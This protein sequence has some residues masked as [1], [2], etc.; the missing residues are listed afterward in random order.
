MAV[1]RRFGPWEMG[2][3]AEGL[4]VAEESVS[5][6]F[7]LSD[8][9]WRAYP[10]EV[11]TLAELMPVEVTNK[12]LAQ[13]LRL[14]KPPTANQLRGKDFFRICMQDHNLLR[15]V[16]REGVQDIMLPLLTYVLSHELV[17]IVRFYKFQHLFDAGPQKKEA[18]E[19]KVHDVTANILRR[20]RL[21]QLDR[22]L[23]FYQAH[24]GPDWC[25]VS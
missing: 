23:N 3:L 21:P 11:R 16:K 15:V 13:V 8:T 18:E 14:R 4:S 6:F 25:W 1:S 12:A 24:H 10:Y 9:A 20:V 7:R 2:L 17:H 5:D 19:K 22:V